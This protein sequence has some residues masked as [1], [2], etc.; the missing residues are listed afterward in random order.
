MNEKSFVLGLFSFNQQHKFF[1]FKKAIPDFAVIRKDPF[2]WSK[3][4]MENQKSNKECD[5]QP[6][7]ILQAIVP[8][9]KARYLANM[10]GIS[11][12]LV[13]KWQREPTS[14]ENPNATG[15][16]NPLERTERILEFAFLYAPE[17]AQLLVSHYQAMLDDFY[18]RVARQPLTDNEWLKKLAK[19]NREIAEAISAIIE[20]QPG[21]I[22]RKEWEEAKTVIEEIVT[23][24]EAGESHSIS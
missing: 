8:R 15:A 13:L 3:R 17:A 7:E 24:R 23:R 16:Q 20:G 9:G 10:L 22:T 6:Y 21:S 1:C 2:Q 14:D 5:M 12:S 19:G 4:T 11:E 18:E